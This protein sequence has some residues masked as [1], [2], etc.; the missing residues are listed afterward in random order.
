MKAIE[1]ILVIC[2][3]HMQPSPALKRGVELARKA[4]AELHLAIFDHDEAIERTAA[5]VN[6]EV[7]Q[8]AKDQFLEERMDWLSAQA[9]AA[10]ARGLRANCDV[11]W[12]A[13][14]PEAIVAKTMELQ[15]DLVV[16]D[17]HLQAGIKRALFLPRDW[18]LV[19]F[20]PAP[21]ML[22]APGSDRLPRH[23]L[24]GVDAWEE[25]PEPAP[26][27]E[28]VVNAALRIA[29]YADGQVDVASV[30]PPIP[31]TGAA[32]R[33]MA[34]AVREA[35][36]CYAEAFRTLSEHLQVPA[37]RRHSLQGDPA[38]SL[39]DLAA[40]MRADLLVLGT[41]FRSGWQRLFLGSTAESVL[42]HAQ[43]DLLLVKPA[44]VLD[45]IAKHLQL[46][47]LDSV[48]AR[49]RKDSLKQMKVG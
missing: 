44:G 13:R 15:P 46:G 37:E 1:R 48:S 39:V 12:S 6:P 41:H 38:L 24:A 30:F 31:V 8:R 4:G 34:S 7:M 32:Y 23:I 20:C 22:V 14:M 47:P 17:T 33:R 3:P 18:K 28:A 25:V 9:A 11:I 49:R 35:E 29:L 10:A 40:R 19:R 36:R 27:N 21:L 2:D 5:L 16:K 43:C 42:S 26:L 45:E